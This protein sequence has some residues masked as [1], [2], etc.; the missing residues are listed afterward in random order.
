MRLS[1]K[2]FNINGNC[3][4]WVKKRVSNRGISGVLFQATECILS[5][6]GKV[7]TTGGGRVTFS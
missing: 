3:T 4:Y 5:G 2:I 1:Q 7:M 6:F